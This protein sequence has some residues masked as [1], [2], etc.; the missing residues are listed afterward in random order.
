VLAAG[1]ACLLTVSL[2]AGCTAI[3]GPS[4]IDD[5]WSRIERSRFV[6]FVRPG[7]FAEP[8][9]SVFNDAMEGQYA[10]TAG[11]FGDAIAAP[12]AVFVQSAAADGAQDFGGSAYP[13]ALTVHVVL[14]TPLDETL[15]VLRHELNHVMV[16]N[17]VGRPGTYFVNEGLADAL[18]FQYAGEASVGTLHRWI[19]AHRADLPRTADLIDDDKWV[20]G[21]LRYKASASLLTYLMHRGG[22]DSIRQFY[23]LPSRQLPDTLGQIYGAPID[24]IERDWMAWLDAANY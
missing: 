6:F 21:E 7:S 2:V 8:Q 20:S 1:A 4:S 16:G 5:N 22:V 18:A 13:T 9:I 3:L 11:L 10:F 23:N 17:A 12:I 15:H 19:V 14:R 24:A